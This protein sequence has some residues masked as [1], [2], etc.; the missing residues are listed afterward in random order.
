MLQQ[1]LFIVSQGSVLSQYEIAEKMGIS[2]DMVLQVARELTN[3]GYLQNAIE[4][5]DNSEGGACSGCTLGS[6][7][8]INIHSWAL[9]EKGEKAVRSQGA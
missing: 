5:C 6:A 2:P 4:A 7:C 1:L 8:H 3:K 9:T